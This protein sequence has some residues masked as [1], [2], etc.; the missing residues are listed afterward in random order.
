GHEAFTAMRARGAQ[1]TDL[2]VLVVAADDH[3]MPQTLEAI[4]HARAASVPIVIAINKI[5][6]PTADPERIRRELSER[7]ILVEDWG[8]TYQCAEI[9]AKKGTGVENLLEE[10]ILAA[11]MLDLKANPNRKARGIIIESRLDRGRGPLATVL[12]QTGTLKTGDKFVGGAHAGRVKAM[13]DERGNKL[14]NV[15]P[16]YPIQ[17]LGFDGTPQAGETVIVMDSEKDVKSVSGKRQ[18]LQRAQAFKQIRALSLESLSKQIKDGEVSELPLIIKGDVNGSVEALSDAL[19]KLNSDE[20]RV[21]IIHRGV[22]AITE[23]DVNLAAASSALIIGFMVHPNLKAK[24]KASNEHVEIRIYRIIYDVIND[25]KAALEGMLAPDI[26][27]NNIGTLQVRQTFKVP[28]M[29]LIAGCHVQAGKIER[30]SKVRLIRDGQ[31]IYEGRI[32]SLKR[33][34]EDVKEVTEGYECGVG[35]ENFNDVKVEDVIEVYELVETKRKL[36]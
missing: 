9:S 28:K 1:V 8:G 29:G 11:E 26:S 13:F 19:M 23:H 20:V 35:I 30:H 24:E 7:D 17:L 10:I 5:D 6:K 3:V 2:V 34:K 14:D 22:G 18:A 4:N 32:H 36:A 21:N 16:G 15:L 33:F 12:I 31:E 25:V 27:E